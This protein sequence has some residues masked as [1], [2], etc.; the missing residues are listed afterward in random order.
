M[1]SFLA[2]KFKILILPSNKELLVY[3]LL[4]HLVPRKKNLFKLFLNG[5]S[6][7]IM[8]CLRVILANCCVQNP[9][10]MEISNFTSFL[11]HQMKLAKNSNFLSPD[12][13]EDFPGFRTFVTRFLIQMSKDFST[14]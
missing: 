6:G 10:W 3:N 11:N 5:F 4:G 1:T 8:D 13:S 2:K 7:N 14:R 12:A 9:T